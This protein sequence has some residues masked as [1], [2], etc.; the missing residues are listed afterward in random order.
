MGEKRAGVV[1]GFEADGGGVGLAIEERLERDR[2]FVVRGV[3]AEAQ[4]GVTHRSPP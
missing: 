2:G 4:G 1:A 3:V